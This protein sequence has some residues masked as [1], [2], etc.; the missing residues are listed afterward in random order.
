MRQLDG[1]RVS[2][3]NNT[4]HQM[5]RVRAREIELSGTNQSF[6]KFELPALMSHT[7]ADCLTRMLKEHALIMAGLS[8]DENVQGVS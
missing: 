2:Q 4:S 7:G 6:I 8:E 3:S 1:A 5:R